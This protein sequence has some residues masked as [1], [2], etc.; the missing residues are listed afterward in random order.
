MWEQAY[1][2]IFTIAIL[3]PTTFSRR[4]FTSGDVVPL[5]RPLPPLPENPIMAPQKLTIQPGDAFD[6]TTFKT[7]FEIVKLSARL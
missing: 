7:G 1:L 6:D 2:S 3:H 4:K 5:N